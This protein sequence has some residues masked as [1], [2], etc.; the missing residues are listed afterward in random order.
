MGTTPYFFRKRATPLGQW[1]TD[2]R[3]KLGF[4]H[5]DVAL[6]LGNIDARFG[7]QGRSTEFETGQ[8]IPPPEIIAKLY[9]FY[10]DRL[11]DDCPPLP[12]N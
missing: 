3:L 9:E 11:G 8:R 1:L 6:I 7:N 12:I 2:C 10:K 4:R 5:S